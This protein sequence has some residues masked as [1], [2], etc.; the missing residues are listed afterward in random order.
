MRDG[1]HVPVSPWQELIDL[2][3]G[4]PPVVRSDGRD[5]IYEL[6]ISGGVMAEELFLPSPRTRLLLRC[7]DHGEIFVRAILMPHQPQRPRR[8]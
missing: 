8:R 6:R 2:A 3:R 7:D 4:Q 1:V 5:V